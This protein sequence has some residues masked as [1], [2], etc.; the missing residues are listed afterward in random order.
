MSSLL[1]QARQ[2][3]EWGDFNRQ[4]IV[5]YYE[6]YLP[7]A[8]LTKFEYDNQGRVIAITRK[9]ELLPLVLS[10]FLGACIHSYRSALDTAM[11][12]LVSELKGDT[13]RIHFPFHETE[14]NLRQS[15][16]NKGGGNKIIST[17]LPDLT[18]LIINEIK[19]YKD[20][21]Y[22]LWALNKLDNTE[23]HTMLLPVL[24]SKIISDNAKGYLLDTDWSF[25]TVHA[26]EPGTEFTQRCPPIP[27]DQIKLEDPI[28]GLMFPRGHPLAERPLIEGLEELS[29]AVLGIIETFETHFNSGKR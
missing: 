10:H 5:H 9:V 1:L 21:N 12:T 18:D 14:H 2:K 26:A 8:V 6:Q 11:T 7:N 29:K 23:K 13:K 25:P 22:A 28:G 20:G 27:E 4:A 19:P 16:S 17:L 24:S 3:V 15:F